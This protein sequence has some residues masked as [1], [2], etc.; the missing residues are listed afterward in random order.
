L[1]SRRASI[2]VLAEAEARLI[3][4]QEAQWLFAAARARA[5]AAHAEDNVGFIDVTLTVP[6]FIADLPAFA[7]PLSRELLAALADSMRA[8]TVRADIAFALGARFVGGPEVVRTAWSVYL[9]PS[10]S[11]DLRLALIW[12]LGRGGQRN[13]KAIP[14]LSATAQDTTQ[15]GVADASIEALGLIGDRAAF[16]LL[17]NAHGEHAEP[18]TF[19]LRRLARPLSDAEYEAFASGS[20]GFKL[21]DAYSLDAHETL[22]SPVSYETLVPFLQ[23]DSVDARRAAAFLL[24]YVASNEQARLLRDTAIAQADDLT[25]RIAA[26]AAQMLR[27]RPGQR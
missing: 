14:L 3:E 4:D 20:L 18:A 2:S 23:S 5:T 8:N 10:A 25:H 24:A 19:A 22:S 11:L 6:E 17:L 15:N 1:R 9:E 26:R 12:M 16:G 7:G 13:R 21:L 27:A